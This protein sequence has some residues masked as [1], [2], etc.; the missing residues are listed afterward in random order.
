MA[1]ARDPAWAWPARRVPV[2][3]RGLATGVRPRPGPGAVSTLGVPLLGGRGL[4]GTGAAGMAPSG[5]G[6]PR[7]GHGPSSPG[8][9][10]WP[11]QP[12][13]SGRE[14]PLAQVLAGS[15]TTVCP[16]DCSTHV[17]KNSAIADEDR[18]IHNKTEES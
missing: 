8:G 10:A 4:D 16:Q 7:R 12:K 17:C 14:T 6:C 15:A 5:R 1:Q 11:Q 2:R 18:Q 13:R 3:A 9:V